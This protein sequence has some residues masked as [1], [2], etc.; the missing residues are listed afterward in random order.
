MKLYQNY[1]YATISEVVD[2]IQSDPFLRDGSTITGVTSTIDDITINFSKKPRTATFTPPN[3]T[4][5][6]QA[7]SYTGLSIADANE[8]GWLM[9]LAMITAWGI[10]ILRRTL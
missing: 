5:I 6:G 4:T 7:N 3:C 2:A 10:K 9:S 1:C 8:L